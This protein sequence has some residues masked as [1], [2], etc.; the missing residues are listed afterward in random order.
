MKPIMLGPTSPIRGSDPSAGRIRGSGGGKGGEG[1]EKSLKGVLERTER[2]KLSAHASSRL[3]QRGIHLSP[4][5]MDQIRGAVDV[6]AAKGGRDSL[7]VTGKA[8]LVVN[9]P[10]RT[11]VTAMDRQETAMRVITNIDSAVVL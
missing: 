7:V 1:F 8:A 2:I 11:V 10:N 4:G 9:V 5:D 3:E 6:A